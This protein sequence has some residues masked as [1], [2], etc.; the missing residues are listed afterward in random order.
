[1]DI[2]LPEFLPDTSFVFWTLFA[3][4][5]LLL[6]L[7][8]RARRR[9]KSEEI[10]RDPSGLWKYHKDTQYRRKRAYKAALD[11][12]EAEGGEKKKESKKKSKKSAAEE[13]Q[14][15]VIALSFDGDLRAKQHNA[16]ARMVDEIVLNKEKIEEVVIRVTSP[17]GT[18]PQYGHAYSE[19]ERL[20]E[21]G[22]S[23]TVCVDVVAA[24]GG[25]L[26]SLPANRI[27]AAPFAMVGSVGVMAFVPNVR[28]LLQKHD[29]DPRMFYA[30]NLKRTVGLV[31][32]ATPEEQAHFQS[33]LD[34]IHELFRASVLKYRPDAKI[35]QI[36]TGDHWTAAESM[37][38]QLGLV[39]ELG[40]SSEYLLRKNAERDVVYLEVKRNV[41]EER[42]GALTSS[43]CDR[44]ESRLFAFRLGL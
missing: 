26:M 37:E 25:Y 39:D 4:I 40:T 1:M 10:E 27:I 20:R 17:G 38:L 12:E 32:Q 30:G 13:E 42:F 5:L 43:V 33:Q 11:A 15:L 2:S 16:L 28:K 24:S 23:L 34:A 8:T 3:L 44:I 7:F 41:W 31:D 6:W 29:I 9:K 35:D 36:T 18:V 14:K 21:L 19:L 22:I